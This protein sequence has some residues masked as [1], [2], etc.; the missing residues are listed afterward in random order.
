MSSPPS[1][2]PLSRVDVVQRLGKDQ[3]LSALTLGTGLRDSTRD[4]AG[5]GGA[6]VVLVPPE[7]AKSPISATDADSAGYHADRSVTVRT[8]PDE[9]DTLRSFDAGT[10]C[11]SF[12]T[13]RVQAVNRAS[14]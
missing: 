1:T 3:T 5:S 11:Y 6:G 14:K 13:T 10:S 8:L 12:D 4:I 7:E 9:Y 2:P